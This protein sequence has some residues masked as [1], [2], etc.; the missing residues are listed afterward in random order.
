MNQV[1]TK[2]DPF[3]WTYDCKAKIIRIEQET[4]DTKTFV[5]LPNQHFSQPL[6]GQHTEVSV[7]TYRDGFSESR[8]Y[9]ISSISKNT[10]SITVKRQPNGKVSNWLHD[11][12]EVGTELQI[13]PPRGQFIYRNQ[14]KLL[15]IAAGSGITP[16]FSIMKALSRQPNSTRPE[17]SLF[18]RSRNPED[19]IFKDKLLPLSSFS[20]SHISH[21]DEDQADYS[22]IDELKAAFPDLKDNHIFLCG[23]EGFK[24][25]VLEYLSS[26]E[27]DFDKLDV[28]NFIS[29]Q[30]AD[31]VQEGEAFSEDTTVLLKS[32]NVSFTI[33]AS[34]E[35]KTLLE[36]A[37]DHG[38]ELEH[39]CRTGMCGTCRTRLV[40]GKV[41]GNQLGKSIYPC[42]SYPA[43]SQITLE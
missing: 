43:S 16:C 34:D 5:L 27:F 19:T 39:G 9:S 37:E 10:I 41:T 30:S 40:D 14:E 29:T 2:L 13:S 12:A 20:E 17:V 38:I 8:C 25:A 18:Y 28:E 6:P 36:A 15:F 4:P 11:H 42:T 33:K 3:L 35:P 22:L 21:S 7:R 26:I 1:T 23:P 32:L 31:A 24:Q